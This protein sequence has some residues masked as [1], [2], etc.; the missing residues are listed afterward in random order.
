MQKII[1]ISISTMMIGG[2]ATAYQRV[3]FTGGKTRDNQL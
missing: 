3:D 2:C 1:L